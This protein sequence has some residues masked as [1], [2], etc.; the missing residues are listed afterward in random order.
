MKLVRRLQRQV[1]INIFSQMQVAQCERQIM[2]WNLLLPLLPSFE[3]CQTKAR[4]L[5]RRILLLGYEM[6]YHTQPCEDVTI[7]L[8]FE[9]RE[10]FWGRRLEYGTSPNTLRLNASWRPPRSPAEPARILPSIPSI[11]T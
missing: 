9:Y 2:F 6:Q 5:P 11:N 4:P 1:L 3:Q 10:K 7:H 8:Q